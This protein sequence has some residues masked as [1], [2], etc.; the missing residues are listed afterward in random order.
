[1][2]RVGVKSMHSLDNKKILAKQKNDKKKLFERFTQNAVLYVFQ[3]LW[4][5]HRRQAVS[6]PE[7]LDKFNLEKSFACSCCDHDFLS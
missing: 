5:V 1:M 7:K 3:S 4:R 6:W 2:G